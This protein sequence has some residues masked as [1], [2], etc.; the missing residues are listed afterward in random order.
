MATPTAP[1]FP[2]PRGAGR[3]GIGRGAGA[4]P[5]PPDP[6]RRRRRARRLLLLLLLAVS[7]W[8]GG[9]AGDDAAQVPAAPLLR[10]P[11]GAGHRLLHVLGRQRRAGRRR[12]RQEGEREAP[13]PAASPRRAAGRPPAPLLPTLSPLFLRFSSRPQRVPRGGRLLGGLQTGSRPTA[14]SHV[15]GRGQR[16]GTGRRSQPGHLL[17]AWGSPARRRAGPIVGRGRVGLSPLV[18]FY[19]NRFNCPSPPGVVVGERVEVLWWPV[20]ERKR[21]S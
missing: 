18:V 9:G 14:P 16:G 12:R 8:P 3:R 20:V 4:R 6:A 7:W 2:A 13:F 15:A 11:L 1:P 17:L 5:L 19:F 21:G 10:L